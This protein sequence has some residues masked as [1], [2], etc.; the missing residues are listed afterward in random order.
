MQQ[1]IRQTE[2]ALII[3]KNKSS[4]L[5]KQMQ[6]VTWNI[7]GNLNVKSTEYQLFIEN[8]T[9]LAHVYAFQETLG[10]QFIGYVK[11]KGSEFGQLHDAYRI[12]QDEFGVTSIYLN[13]TIFNN[14]VP[15]L[16]PESLF[17][18]ATGK[19]RIYTSSA[20]IMLP[21]TNICIINIYRPPLESIKRTKQ[22]MKQIQMVIDWIR[23]FLGKVEAEFI[24]VGDTNVW[25]ESFG[26]PNR[27]ECNAM[28]FKYKQGD[29]LVKLIKYKHCMY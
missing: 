25:H 28:S 5:R 18:D 20:L 6:I 16:I 21:L 9:N 14:Y 19:N 27:I 23:Q 1:I 2:Q 26:S 22:H 24:I 11:R 13:T 29:L 7:N 3:K 4:R 10:T 17:K 8:I 12:T 15:I